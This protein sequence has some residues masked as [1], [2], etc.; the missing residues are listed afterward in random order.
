MD[1]KDT[2]KNLIVIVLGIW[3]CMA[4]SLVEAS[5]S[6]AT[7]YVI[8]PG[9]VLDIS[10]WKVEELTKVVVVLP[11]GK[12][13]FPLVGNIQAAGKNVNELSEIIN[14]K[15]TR[16]IPHPELSVV[17]QQVNSMQIYV[18]GQVNKPGRLFLNS[19]VNVL[20][21]IAMAGGL[22]P[23]AIKKGIKVFREAGGRTA[24]FQFKYK[25]AIK[26]ENLAQNIILKRGDTVV[27]P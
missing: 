2:M 25:E 13:G 26:G 14:S 17:V 23:F 24:I 9:D 11:D 4:S 6:P 5:E 20:Q 7:D 19:N 12:I 16:Y 10:V 21:A 18:V 1:G 8:G 3:V 15:L 22:N 27:V